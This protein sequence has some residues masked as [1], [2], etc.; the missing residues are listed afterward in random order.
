MQVILNEQG[1]VKAYAFI[2]DFGTNS[3]TV[4]EPEDLHDF[5][6]NH[7]SYHIVNGLLVKNGD[8]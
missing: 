6:M 3:V 8:R 5:E 4:N 7:R 2:G 1:Y